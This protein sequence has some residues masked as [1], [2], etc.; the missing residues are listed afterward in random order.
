VGGCEGSCEGGC[1]REVWMRKMKGGNMMLVG[2]YE[3]VNVDAQE[4]VG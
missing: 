4:V 1:E 3:W 2:E